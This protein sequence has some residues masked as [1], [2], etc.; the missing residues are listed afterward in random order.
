MPENLTDEQTHAVMQT[1]R[2]L[3]AGVAV[4]CIDAEA[5]DELE[6]FRSALRR[7]LERESPRRRETAF[8]RLLLEGSERGKGHRARLQ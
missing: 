3:G 1:V 4:H 2:K 5:L 8:A 7:V 6:H